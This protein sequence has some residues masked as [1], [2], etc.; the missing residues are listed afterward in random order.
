MC[1]GLTDVLLPVAGDLAVDLV[2]A[3]LAGCVSQAVSTVSVL[4]DTLPVLSV[5]GGAV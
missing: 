3:V 4:G 2:G 5:R 1:A